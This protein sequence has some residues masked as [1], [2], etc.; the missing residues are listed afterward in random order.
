MPLYV[1][2][3]LKD[4]MH[5]SPEQHGVYDLL[6]MNYWIRGEALPDNDD[7]LARVSKSSL[8][9]W[10]S[11]R[12]V[13]GSFFIIGEGLWR[14]KR[15]ELELEKAR[16]LRE[17]KSKGGKMG[18]FAKWRG[19]AM[20]VPM[21]EACQS[22][23]SAN[24]TANGTPNETPYGKTM[25]LQPSHSPIEYN[26]EKV[27]SLVEPPANFPKT[28]DEAKAHAA[29]VGCTEDFAELTWHKAMSRGGRDARDIPVRNWR[30]FLATEWT[31]HKAQQE[32]E[33]RKQNAN[34]PQNSQRSSDRAAGTLNEGKASQ[35]AGIGKI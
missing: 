7:Y 34:N 5:L 12:S 2:D 25:T 11:H 15:V 4:T 16:K 28:L 3:Y 13:I 30:S 23:D 33:K 32:K 29:F 1:G 24:G 35:Y 6:I 21:A 10:H 20:P 26:I 22:D 17:S 18:A 31:F 27:D 19:K 8:E 14:H 9:T